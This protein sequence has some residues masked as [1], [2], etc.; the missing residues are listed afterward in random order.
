MPLDSESNPKSSFFTGTVGANPLNTEFPP[1]NFLPGAW[2]YVRDRDR[3]YVLTST[4]GAD[5]VWRLATPASILGF[6][7]TS[8]VAGTR[9]LYPWFGAAASVA[10]APAATNPAIICP[11]N[12]LVFRMDQRITN[13]AAGSTT[14]TTLFVNNAATALDVPATAGATGTVTLATPVAIAA[15]SSL[16]CRIIVTGAVRANPVVSIYLLATE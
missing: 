5:R 9:T 13:A 2:L 16:A 14:A 11:Y 12:A 3:L 1:A 6:G 7:A 10:G 4:T 15:G 8:S